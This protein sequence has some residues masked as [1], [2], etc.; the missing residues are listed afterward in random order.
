MRY[1][2]PVV[3][4]GLASY[5]WQS[6]FA[7]WPIDGD[8]HGALI[9]RTA[10]KKKRGGVGCEVPFWPDRYETPGVLY[11]STFGLDTKNGP[12][13][14]SGRPRYQQSTSG[15]RMIPHG[16]G[17]VGPGLHIWL[18]ISYIFTRLPPN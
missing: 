12:Q 1:S 14:G 13:R 2:I 18:A 11:V 5:K 16:H 10:V 15:L 9:N 4:L 3:K 8:S 17:Y 7:L 6:L